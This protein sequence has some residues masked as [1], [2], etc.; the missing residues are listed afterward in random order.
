VRAC[1]PRREG[2][3]EVHVKTRIQLQAVLEHLDDVNVMVA[4]K[5]DL[6]EVVLIE[7]N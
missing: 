6:A 4:F 7:E 2:C 5:V 1:R 3:V